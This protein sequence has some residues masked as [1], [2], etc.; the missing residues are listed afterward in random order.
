M[1]SLLYVIFYTL[2]TTNL[3]FLAICDILL[4]GERKVRIMTLGERIKQQREAKGIT[5]LEL[6]RKIGYNTTGA[7]SL[8]ESGKRDLSLDKVCEIAKA[9]DVTPHWLL[10]WADSPLEIKT[11]M[12]LTIDELEGLDADQLAKVRD[13]IQFIKYEGSKR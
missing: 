10:G 1:S 5:Q 2:S 6:A 9:L 4:L 13:Y 3:R 8:I 12:E 7:I 11:D